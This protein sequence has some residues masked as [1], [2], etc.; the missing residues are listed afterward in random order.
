MS[1]TLRVLVLG[2]SALSGTGASLPNAIGI[3]ADSMKINRPVE[4]V[5]GSAI[6]MTSADARAHFEELSRN[7]HFDAVVVYVGNCDASSFGAAK[8]DL[9]KIGR[10][11][12]LRKL[13][14]NRARYAYAKRTR[15][16][17]F[18]KMPACSKMPTR[19][20]SPDDF[21][22]HLIA[23]VAL[24]RKKDTIMIVLNPVAQRLFPPCNN[25][26]NFVFYQIPNLRHKLELKE[27]P[28]RL[29]QPW[30]LEC[31]DELQSSQQVYNDL[32]SKPTCDETDFIA[33]MNSAALLC[34]SGKWSDAMSTLDRISTQSPMLP[35]V[36]YA[37]AVLFSVQGR[38]KEAE[39]LFDSAYMQDSGS[40]RITPA[41]RQKIN[42]LKDETQNSRLWI[43]DL[44]TELVDDNILDYCHPDI[45]GQQKIAQLIQETLYKSLNLSPGNYN[46]SLNYLP[47]NPDRYTGMQDNFFKYFGVI[48]ASDNDMAKKIV[49]DASH[50]DYTTLLNNEPDFADS[51]FDRIFHRLVIHPVMGCK[52]F[53]MTSPP[54]SDIDQ[55]SLCELYHL[56][57][58]SAALDWPA[59]KNYT[60]TKGLL[61][62]Q[63][64]IRLWWPGLKTSTVLTSEAELIACLSAVKP[65]QALS[66]T[67]QLLLNLCDQGWVANDR[68]RT[69]SHWFMREALIFGSTSHYLMYTNRLYCMHALTSSLLLANAPCFDVVCQEKANELLLGIH[70]WIRLHNKT[71]KKMTHA[72]SRVDSVS[73]A[74]YS[75]ALDELLA[76]ARFDIIRSI[77]D[78]R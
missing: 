35:L 60:S 24:A 7:E 48:T 46:A 74:V 76:S 55:G 40:Y 30:S 49:K 61:P 19:C 11:Y 59:F 67:A 39:Y 72:L 78:A 9:V 41:Y 52:E 65:E 34:E 53:L 3:L 57:H 50:M 36:I 5:N 45:K 2:D 73:R 56:R 12:R 31:R 15:P 38:E 75:D 16:L 13:A 32:L 21:S 4:L 20:V 62:Q 66:R 63:E 27:I 22:A 17:Y 28:E 68:C 1:N 33:A 10:H 25:T 29:K 43:I 58:I 51:H 70:D 14:K 26:G 37:R 42:Q 44:A 47:L 8:P 23:M 71:L 54:V 77:A 69:I 18:K 6:G 64:L